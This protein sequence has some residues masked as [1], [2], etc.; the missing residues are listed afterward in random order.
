MIIIINNKNNRINNFKTKIIKK[1]NSFQ[2][3][4]I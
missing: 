1:N 2:L 3:K 4:N